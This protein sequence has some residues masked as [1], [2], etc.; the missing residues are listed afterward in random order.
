MVAQK[1]YRRILILKKE[2]LKTIKFYSDGS[3]EEIL[4]SQEEAEENELNK[5]LDD[6]FSNPVA[7]RRIKF[8]V[9]AYIVAKNFADK[10]NND[11]INNSLSF[12]AKYQGVTRQTVV[13]KTFRQLNI[14]STKYKIIMAE[15]IYKDRN[16]EQLK[17]LLL[18]YVGTRTEVA[19]KSLIEKFII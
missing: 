12:L 14:T 7:S 5:K 15:A 6:I 1:L 17:K 3:Y 16:T 13:D 8:N 9:G 19:D 2:L 4:E 18:D 11:A 10:N